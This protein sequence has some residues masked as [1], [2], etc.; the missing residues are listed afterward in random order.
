MLTPETEQETITAV[1]QALVEYLWP[2]APGGAMGE[3]WGFGTTISSIELLAQVARIAGVRAVKAVSLFE[4]TSTGWQRLTEGS[5]MALEV[6]QLPELMGVAVGTGDGEPDFPS[7]LAYD[8][9]A[10]SG[11]EVPAPVIP[12]MC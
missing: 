5:E 8:E 7:G 3:G 10:D 2:T 11:N 12:E 9:S 1:Q 6:Y 4:K